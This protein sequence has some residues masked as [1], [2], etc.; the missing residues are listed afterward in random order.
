MPI[1]AAAFT[2]LFA[3]GGNAPIDVSTVLTAMVGWHLVI[4]LGEAAVTALVVGS[5][6][7]VRPDLVRGARGLI[8]DREL[9]IRPSPSTASATRGSAHGRD[10]A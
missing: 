6:V 9:E 10:T 2:L 7:A 8:A 1:A 3:V 4:G 5:V